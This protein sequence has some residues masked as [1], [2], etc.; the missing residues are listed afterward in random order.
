MITSH[1]LQVRMMN[2]IFEAQKGGKPVTIMS[3]KG[4]IEIADFV[5]CPE[6]DQFHITIGEFAPEVTAEDLG[7]HDV[8]LG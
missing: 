1:G 4:P 6:C 8:K 2:V 3:N 7:W 5:W